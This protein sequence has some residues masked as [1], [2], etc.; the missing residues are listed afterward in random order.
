MSIVDQPLLQCYEPGPGGRRRKIKPNR[1]THWLIEKTYQETAVAPC[2]LK[3]IA[4]GYE[5]ER[6]TKQ[7]SND[8]EKVTCFDCMQVAIARRAECQ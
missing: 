8:K 1:A 3:A 2:R 6:A 7:S 5:S 4:C